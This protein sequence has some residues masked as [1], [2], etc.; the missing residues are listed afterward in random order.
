MWVKY[1]MMKCA[2]CSCWLLSCH[3]F[4][5][6]RE[7]CVSVPSVKGTAALHA[8]FDSSPTQLSYT[9]RSQRWICYPELFLSHWIRDDGIKSLRLE[10]VFIVDELKIVPGGGIWLLLTFSTCCLSICLPEARPFAR[11]HT[12]VRPLGRQPE[13]FL[14]DSCY[15]WHPTSPPSPPAIPPAKLRT[16]AEKNIWIST[17]GFWRIS[18]HLWTFCKFICAY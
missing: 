2:R 13:H 17:S 16:E 14:P 12:Y 10:F 6:N 18:Q 8:D 11:N 3:L 5:F 4:F 15:L 9:G 1:K 7:E